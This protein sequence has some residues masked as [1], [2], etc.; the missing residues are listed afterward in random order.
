[1]YISPSYTEPPPIPPPRYSPFTF[2]RKCGCPREI[3]GSVCAYHTSEDLRR[4][5][6][7][8]ASNGSSAVLW[9]LKKIR[10]FG[11]DLNNLYSSTPVQKKPNTWQV[12]W[13]II[14]EVNF[15]GYHG[16]VI[17]CTDDDD[18]SH[19]HTRLLKKKKSSRKLDEYDVKWDTA[20]G[21]SQVETTQGE[22]RHAPSSQTGFI[23]TWWCEEMSSGVF[24]C[25]LRLTAQ[26]SA[27]V[28]DTLILTSRQRRRAAPRNQSFAH[29]SFA[30]FV[31]VHNQSLSNQGSSQHLYWS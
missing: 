23:W 14:T 16:N 15:T 18:I 24:A 8:H 5:S 2:C 10:S 31:T 4:S 6:Q 13:Y 11:V 1:M 25:D 7:I 22:S 19:G 20:Q 9:K 28:T 30:A 3:P 12:C 21:Y 29:T 17:S 26:V 27:R